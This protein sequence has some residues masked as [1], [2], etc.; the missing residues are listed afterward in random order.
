[1]EVWPSFCAVCGQRIDREDNFCRRCGRALSKEPLESDAVI[2]ASPAPVEPVVKE[3]ARPA[4]PV[5][6]AAPVERFGSGTASLF[7]EP[8][9]D[10]APRDPEPL[11]ASPESTP[12]AG[13]ALP[14]VSSL[15]TPYRVSPA[16]RKPRLPVLEILV[17]I[18][19][20]GGAGIAVWMVR[21]S[22]PA[23]QAAS[24]SQVEVTITPARAQ[25][26][27]GKACDLSATV[28]GSDD[29]Q[30]AWSVREGDAGGRIINRGARAENGAVSL[31]AVYVAPKMPGTYHV[32]ATSN[33]DPDKSA[34][35]EMVVIKH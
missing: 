30:V 3:V 11:P 20:A 29:V 24:A 16:P 4:E 23:K 14:A 26:V 13:E 12:T 6:E 8:V 33:A 27:A 5:V 7:A 22:V 9:R 15:E 19:L 34:E 25:V 1:M 32:V 31:Q 10:E 2:P 21:S 28:S 18:L 17:V 35:A